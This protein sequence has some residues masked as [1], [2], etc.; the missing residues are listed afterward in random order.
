MRKFQLHNAPSKFNSTYL[1]M[2]YDT[3]FTCD[4]TE[5]F[6]SSQKN[7][8]LGARNGYIWDETKAAHNLE[9]PNFWVLDFAG[10]IQHFHL[11]VLNI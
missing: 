11:V 4:F 9:F 3:I 7:I 10:S 2:C 6:F 1:R 8:P 5:F